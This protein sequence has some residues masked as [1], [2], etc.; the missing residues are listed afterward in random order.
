V[1]RVLEGAATG[2]VKLPWIGA[3]GQAV[4]S[5]LASSVGLSRPG[6]VL[7]KSV[8]GPGPVGRAG[9]KT[10]DVILSVD[11][12]PVD[13][14]QSLNYRIATHKPGDTVKLHVWSNG[15]ARD[16]QAKLMLAPEDPPRQ[17]TT[18]SGRNP[19]TGAKIE[20]LSPATA[21]DFG[22][23]TDAKGVVVVST[24]PGTPAD[25]YGF[26]RG[27]IVVEVNG[28]KIN[29]VGDLTRALDSGQG[30]W[31]MIVDRGG[32]QMQLSVRG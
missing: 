10:G 28:A 25:G 5:S 31:S 18:I 30:E 4:T 3:D 21:D 11:G 6:G 7:L 26:Q 16:V 13:D 29:R 8:Y 1:R 2:G 22:F 27:D 32:R 17:T 19:M 14:M 20:N 9:L 23:G 24:A 15:K 12:T